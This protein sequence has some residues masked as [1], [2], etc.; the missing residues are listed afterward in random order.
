MITLPISMFNKLR[1]NPGFYAWSVLGVFYICSLIFLWPGVM[2]PDAYTQY[3]AAMAG[4]YHDH[5]PPVMGF[6]WRN[7]AQIY[8]GPATM[9]IFHLSMLYIAA[10]IF[11]YLFR[12]SK[13]K[14]WYVCFP[15]LPNILAYTAL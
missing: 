10:A 7:L 3:A 15:L 8:P 1:T 6:V 12:N 4:V 13:F 5:H 11:V 14:W 9:F 2:S